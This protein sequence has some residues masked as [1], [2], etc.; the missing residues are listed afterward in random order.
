MNNILDYK[1]GSFNF[2]IKSGEIVTFYG[3]CNN[4]ISNLMFKNK[5]DF[6]S[7]EGLS[8]NN[9]NLDVL[10]NNVRFVDVDYM[11]IFNS[12][13]IMDELAFPLENAAMN[14]KEMKEKVEA[15][16]G[17]FNF[18]KINTT[19]PLSL[20]S[21]SRA[22]LQIGCALIVEPK[23]IVLN[24]VLCFLNRDDLAL[25]LAAFSEFIKN[26]GCILNFTSD[27]E[28]SLFGSRIIVLG[29]DKILIEGETLGVLN[30][31]KIM[32]RLGIGLPFVISLSKYLK[33]Y[34]LIDRYYLDYKSLGGALWK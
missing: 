10:R 14:K 9:K 32:K 29:S 8:I 24:N 25:V 3:Q 27:I 16:A 20:D 28:E 33:D 11:D 18:K 6:V 31:E 13:T 17:K 26:G 22:L 23:V 1:D 19:A 2:S 4:I 15:I 5:N 12:E 30:E 7:I 34:E 21:S